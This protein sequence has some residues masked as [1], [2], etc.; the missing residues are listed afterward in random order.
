MSVAERVRQLNLPPDQ[1]VVVGGAVLEVLGIRKSGDIDIIAAELVLHILASDE[2]WSKK[3]L[4]EGSYIYQK[5]GY[6][7]GNDWLGRS[8]AEL[9]SDTF[10][11]DG[12]RYVS[13]STVMAW[14][15]QR[16]RPKDQE[17]LKLIWEYLS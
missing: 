10:E 17:D 15:K 4:A 2:A 14:K 8:F 3:D 9:A 16:N 7:V 6:E 12:I 13:L 1:F 5:E 11:M